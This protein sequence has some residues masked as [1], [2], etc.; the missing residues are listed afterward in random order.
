MPVACVLNSGRPQL[1]AGQAS[2]LA[3]SSFTVASVGGRCSIATSTFYPTRRSRLRRYETP[4]PIWLRAVCA[5]DAVVAGRGS[6]LSSA[7]RDRGYES[8]ADARERLLIPV[9]G[10]DDVAFGERMKHDLEAHTRG[11]RAALV[12]LRERVVPRHRARAA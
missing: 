6:R 10:F 9:P 8:V 1:G 7:D 2:A 3:Y 11:L 4:P 5:R 12:E